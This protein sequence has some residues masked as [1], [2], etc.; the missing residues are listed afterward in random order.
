MGS[1]NERVYMLI[2]NNLCCSSVALTLC[3]LQRGSDNER[4]YKLK[5]AMGHCNIEAGKLAGAALPS[6]VLTA[7]KDPKMAPTLD[8]ESGH[9]L[10]PS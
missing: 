1:H 2:C 3:V 6:P 9:A 8:L 10:L 5:V 7:A 4:V